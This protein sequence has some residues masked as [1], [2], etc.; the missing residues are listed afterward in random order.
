MLVGTR[1]SKYFQGKGM[2]NLV[3]KTKTI[4]EYIEAIK[5]GKYVISTDTSAYHIAALSRIPFLA[6]FTGGVKPAARLNFYTQ[7]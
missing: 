2:I 4:T 6:I 1:D 7:L 5:L 3:G